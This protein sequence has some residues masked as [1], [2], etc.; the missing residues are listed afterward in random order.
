[1]VV[2]MSDAQALG[3]AKVKLAFLRPSHFAIGTYEVIDGD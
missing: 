3:K 2:A 1:M